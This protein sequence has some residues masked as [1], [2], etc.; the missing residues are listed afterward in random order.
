MTFRKEVIDQ[1]FQV[2]LTFKRF[3]KNWQIVQ[4]ILPDE[5]L[6]FGYP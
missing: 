3:E 1:I 2:Q 4:A 5:L 6:L